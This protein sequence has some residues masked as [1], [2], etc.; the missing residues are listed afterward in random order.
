MNESLAGECI[1]GYLQGLKRLRSQLGL[2]FVV[3]YAY[4]VCGLAEFTLF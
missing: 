3:K 4:N 1:C 2:N